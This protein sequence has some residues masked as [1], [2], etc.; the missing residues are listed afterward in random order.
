MQPRMTP[1]LDCCARAECFPMGLPTIRIAELHM[2]WR[3]LKSLADRVVV[4]HHDRRRLMTIYQ[5]ERYSGGRRQFFLNVRPS[6]RGVFGVFLHPG[7]T[8][9]GGLLYHRTFARFVPRSLR[10]DTLAS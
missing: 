7:G 3:R 5:E 8:G 9:S 1:G 10:S 4:R 6:S 2:L